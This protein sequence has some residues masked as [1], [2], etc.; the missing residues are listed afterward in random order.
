MDL[1]ISQVDWNRYMMV[2]LLINVA[3][4]GYISL[5][6][7]GNNHSQNLSSNTVHSMGDLLKLEKANHMTTL[8]PVFYS[9][10]HLPTAIGF[11]SGAAE[12]YCCLSAGGGQ[13]PWK[14]CST[15]AIRRNADNTVPGD[16]IEL[17]GVK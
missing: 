1:D 10:D 2:V 5:T 12:A 15:I 6:A 4:E 9:G 3:Q 16:S 8:F 17:W 7:G 11:G 14:Q 13:K